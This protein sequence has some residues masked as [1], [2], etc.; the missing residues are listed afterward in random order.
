[1]TQETNAPT[2]QNTFSR[3]VEDLFLSFDRIETFLVLAKKD[4]WTS[5]KKRICVCSSLA[6]TFIRVAEFQERSLETLEKLSGKTWKTFLKDAMERA[7][8]EKEP[9]A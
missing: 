7:Q 4:D 5:E 1:M 6:Y 3:I 8:S 9:E 2:Y